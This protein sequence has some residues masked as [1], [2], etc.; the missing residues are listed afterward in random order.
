MKRGAFSSVAF[1]LV[2]SVLT[3]GCRSGVAAKPQLGGV[4]GAKSKPVAQKPAVSAGQGVITCS[5]FAAALQSGTYPFRTLMQSSSATYTGANLESIR[6][7]AVQPGTGSTGY[8][9]VVFFNGTSQVTPDWPVGMLV[10]SSGAL[11]DQAALVFFDYPGIGGTTYP[12]ETA[13][14]F[15]KVSETVYDLLA[16]FNS[17]GTLTVTEVDP[18]G[19]SLGTAS[20]IKFAVLAANNQSFKSSGMSIGK[21]FLIAVKS[22]GDIQ[23]SAATAPSSCTT[24][25]TRSTP[26]KRSTPT[27]GLGTTYYPAIGNQAMCSTSVLNQLLTKADYEGGVKLKNEFAQLMFPYVYQVP[28]SQPQSPYGSITSQFPYG[29][30]DPATICAMTISGLA[31][32]SLCNLEKDQPLETECDS[33]SASTCATA[34]ALFDANREES[35]YLDNISYDDFYG[36]RAM[37]FHFDYASCS[38]ASTTSWQSTGCQ[39]NPNQ[40]GDPLYN[41]ALLVD[42]SPCLTVQTTSADASPTIQSC[43]GIS[44]ASLD[45]VKFYIWNGEED[46]LIRHDY[47]QVF[48][49]WLTNN[50]FPCTYQTFAKAGH[51]VLFNQAST[52]YD[53]MVAALATSASARRR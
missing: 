14:T 25:A 44:S 32:K 37:I 24:A 26:S 39:F 50:K 2:L 13:F 7:L 46:L 52:I 20:A 53:E 5:E 30:G 36:E 42:G 4:A 16:S 19:W 10:S 43:P 45:G 8:P 49:T 17:S 23:S 3:W 48:C 12:G 28:A 1:I 18:A 51:A 9:T 21:L 40:T 29:S 34:L 41:S 15:D 11:C 47:G 22:G 33:N 27:S 35:P 31:V 38:S 6:Y